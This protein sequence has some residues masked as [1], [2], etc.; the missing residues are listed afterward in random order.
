MT[1]KQI[2]TAATNKLIANGKIQASEEIHTYNQW[3][4]MGY[5]VFRG[6]KA[7]IALNIWKF[8]QNNA[9]DQDEEDGKEEGGKMRMKRAYFF[10]TN[11]VFSLQG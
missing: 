4:K 8:F 2:I 7:V 11:Q 10:S 3:K 9:K 1:N 5:Q 6:E